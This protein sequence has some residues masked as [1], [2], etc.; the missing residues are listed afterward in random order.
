MLQTHTPLR[1][2]CFSDAEMKDLSILYG[3]LYPKHAVSQISRFYH[4]SKQAVINGEDFITTQSRSQ[5]SAAV[6]AH[7]PGVL[8]I[9]NLGEAPVRI[10]MIS[11]FIC[12]S[13][14][15]KTN[16]SEPT[17]V[18]HVLARVN[19]FHDHPRRDY[20]HPS[21]ILCANTFECVGPASFIPASRIIARCALAQDCW[22]KFDYGD[23]KVCIAVPLLKK[24][25]I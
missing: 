25:C 17:L 21:V 3:L 23:D 14:T 22:C 24:V 12:H 15:V 19:W 13:V 8:G 7:W 2:K 4:E 20:F 5:R 11:S 1:E 9:D 18:R 6:V 16:M 10:G